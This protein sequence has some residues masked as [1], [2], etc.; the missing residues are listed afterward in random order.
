MRKVVAARSKSLADYKTPRK[1]AVQRDP[2]VRT[3]AGKVRRFTYQG[4]LNE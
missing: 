2:L 1:V 4:A 3:S